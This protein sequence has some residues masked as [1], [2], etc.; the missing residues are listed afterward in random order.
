VAPIRKPTSTVLIDSRSGLSFVKDPGGAKALDALAAQLRRLVLDGTRLRAVGVKRKSHQLAGA[1][2]A[3]RSPFNMN[4]RHVILAALTAALS[5][6][7]ATSALADDGKGKGKEKCYGIAK[8]GQNE[9]G[10]ITGTHTCAGQS[11]VD[12]APDEWKYVA[13]GSCKAAGGKTAEEVKAEAKTAK[14]AKAGQ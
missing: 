5:A 9:C 13:K 6:G 14:P 12:H 1:T 10:S 3:H 8:A 2:P 11:K 4:S 7:A